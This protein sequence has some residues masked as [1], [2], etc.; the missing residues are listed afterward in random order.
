M[1]KKP[2]EHV[3]DE[4]LRT[5]LSPDSLTILDESR[6][7]AGH[8]GAIPGESTH[9]RIK[10]VSKKFAGLSQ[11]ERHRLVYQILER[12]MKDN[13]HALSLTTLEEE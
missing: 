2:L 1:I 13:I 10:V 12:E 9:F 4:K 11:L 8:E 3:I 5:A 7:H 6:K